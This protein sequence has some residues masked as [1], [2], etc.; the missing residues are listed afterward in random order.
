MARKKVNKVIAI[1]A[2]GLRCD[3][4]L[5]KGDLATIYEKVAA[6]AM[7]DAAVDQIEADMKI[8]KAHQQ[9]ELGYLKSQKYEDHHKTLEADG[10][11]YEDE[12]PVFEVK[13]RGGRK[14]TV[15]MKADTEAKFEIDKALSAKATMDVIP[16]LYKKVNITLNKDMIEKAYKDKTLP[17]LMSR[18]CS[19]E[20]VETTKIR[21][22]QEKEKKEEGVE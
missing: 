19:L 12:V 18:L 17:E 14:A 1:D 4:I 8:L 16:E 21:V 13:M 2:T 3:E 10:H 9:Q 6:A 22:V 15:T 11:V 20:E 5:K 7:L